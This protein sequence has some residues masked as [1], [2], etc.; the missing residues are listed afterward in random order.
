VRA[1]DAVS[2]CA[3]AVATVLTATYGMGCRAARV[4][5]DPALAG[6]EKM[7]RSYE[8]RG[9]AEQSGV[10]TTVL[11]SRDHG[12]V[13]TSVTDFTIEFARPDRMK[14]TFEK[15]DEGVARMKG[16][17]WANRSGVH[18]W[19]AMRPLPSGPW[20]YDKRVDGQP[21][22]TAL[23][24]LAGVTDRAS[25]LV[26]PALLGKE[27]PSCGPD[28]ASRLRYVGEDSINGETCDVVALA[29]Q[30]GEE[31]IWIARATG[32]VRR[33]VEIADDGSQR[34][35][36]VTLYG[37]AVPTQDLEEA[38]FDFSPPGLAP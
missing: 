37:A 33:T 27:C 5:P 20:P 23:Y 12:R 38:A 16:A 36:T 11:E 26:P 2:S 9:S 28:L 1:R 34:A 18:R 31:R 7:F 14:F 21:L 24:S 22:E 32:A 35:T 30:L 29:R 15:S 6:I 19:L 8:G 17:V 10:A 4:Q 13:L 3:I 25:W